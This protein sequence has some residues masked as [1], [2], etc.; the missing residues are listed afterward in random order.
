MDTLWV[1]KYRPKSF[2]DVVGQEEAV[3]K[4]KAMAETKTVQHLLFSGP[5]GVGKTTCALILAKESLGENWQDNFMQLNASDDRKLITIQT[6]V[7][8]FSR[9]KPLNSSF[10]IIFLDEAD[11]L[12]SEAQQALR[13]MMEDYGENCRFIF[14]VNYQSNIIEAIQS[15]CVIIRFKSLDKSAVFSLIDKISNSENLEIDEEAKEALFNSTMG[16]LRRLINLMQSIASVSKK[17]TAELVYKS[18]S[19]INL[20][21]IDKIF[22]SALSGDYV[23]SKKELDD[24]ISQ[25]VSPS[26]IINAMYNYVINSDIAVEKKI[27][28]I[29]LIAEADYRI[30]VGATPL[31]QLNAILAKITEW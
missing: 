14:S 6:K 21:K 22:K 25:G 3:R 23:S 30:I 12:T 15:R 1:D 5:P 4:L 19:K 11:S 17:I 18:L 8:E 28:I 20:D 13:R 24:I 10:K 7:K 31:I 2:D 27:K 26:E 9:S 16:D 29:E